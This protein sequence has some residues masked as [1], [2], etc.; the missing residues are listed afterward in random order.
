MKKIYGLILILTTIFLI[1]GCEK[2]TAGKSTDSQNATTEKNDKITIVGCSSEMEYEDIKQF[3]TVDLTSRND[4]LEEMKLNGDMEDVIWEMR[5]K[6][7]KPVAIKSHMVDTENRIDYE[8]FDSLHED[9]QKQILESITNIAKDDFAKEYS[10]LKDDIQ[11]IDI[12]FN[13]ENDTFIM[14]INVDV[15]KIGYERL[16]KNNFI[17]D[18]GF[19]EFPI[20]LSESDPNKVIKDLE[21]QGF[22]CEKNM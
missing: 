5:V 10:D 13:I 1:V 17:S 18:M 21:E 14:D 2:K 22:V 6:N 7:G 16:Q 8:Y 4:V 20:D 3:V 9:N 12:N 11:Y 15:E 19:D